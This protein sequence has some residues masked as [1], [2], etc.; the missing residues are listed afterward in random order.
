ML[1]KV[2][3]MGRFTADPELKQVYDATPVVNFSLAVQRPRKKEDGTRDVDFINCSA[4]RGTAEN[5]CSEMRTGKELAEMPNEL[6]TYKFTIPGRLPGL[7]DYIKAMNTN[8]HSG[9]QMKKVNMESVMWEIYRQIGSKRIKRPVY[10]RFRWVEPDKRRDRDNISSFGRKVILDALVSCQTIRDDGWECVTGFSDRFAVSKTKP[11]I[12]VEIIEQ[13][14]EGE[15][16]T[17]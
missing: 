7:N 10:I 15:G 14:T 8:R 4:W 2:E 16:A 11:H 6:K 3:L 1:N 12:E 13:D 17:E 5:C 9:A